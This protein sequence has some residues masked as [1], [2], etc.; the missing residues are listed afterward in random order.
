MLD[1]RQP[2]VKENWLNARGVWLRFLVTFAV[3]AGGILAAYYS[4]IG[5]I[6]LALARKADQ[7]QVASLDKKLSTLEVLLTT[8]AVTREEFHQFR[9]EVVQRL[10]RIEARLEPQSRGQTIPGD[11]SSLPFEGRGLRHLSSPYQ[12]EGRE[13]SEFRAS[14]TREYRDDD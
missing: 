4:T 13:G 5:R 9:D 14:S 11:E 12:G 6:D 10:G 1:N 2:I 7:E 8:N 3:T